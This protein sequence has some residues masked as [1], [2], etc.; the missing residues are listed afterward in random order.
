M[1]DACRTVS[2]FDGRDGI[3]P[4]A[5]ARKEIAHM[6]GTDFEP[7]RVIRQRRFDD[8]VLARGEVLPVDPNPA[9]RADKLHSVTLTALVNDITRRVIVARRFHNLRHAAGPG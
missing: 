5:D 2:R 6:I 1:T 4:R 8:L 3:F 9:V 7:G